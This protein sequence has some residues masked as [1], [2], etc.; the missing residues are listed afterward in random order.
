MLSLSEGG[1]EERKMADT[2]LGQ[3]S[4]YESGGQ[5]TQVYSNLEFLDKKKANKVQTAVTLMLAWAV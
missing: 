4:D 5:G 2:K 3:D 1:N